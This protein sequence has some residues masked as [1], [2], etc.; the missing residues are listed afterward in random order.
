MQTPLRRGLRLS[1]L[2]LGAFTTIAS[3]GL[4]LLGGPH[5]EAARHP[6]FNDGGAMHWETRFASAIAQATNSNR[7][8]F[9]EVGS[10]RCTY[11]KLLCKKVLPHPSVK[12]RISQTAIGLAVDPKTMDASLRA[13]FDANLAKRKF[14]PWCAFLTADGRWIYGW[15]GKTSVDEFSGHLSVAEAARARTSRA[16]RPSAGH[17]LSGSSSA[18]V[19]AVSPWRSSSVS[20]YVVSPP[21]G[22]G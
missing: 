2:L 8:I 18:D 6:Y 10:K 15:S 12:T 22:G 5:A 11:C 13:V 14:Y 16:S 21:V 3:L 4:A 20:D 7:L 19:G 9:V 17:A 1:T